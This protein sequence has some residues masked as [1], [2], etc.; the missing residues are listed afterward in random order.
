MRESKKRDQARQYVDFMVSEQGQQ[1]VS[2][3]GIRRAKE[4]G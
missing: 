1:A 2:T 3:N 4:I